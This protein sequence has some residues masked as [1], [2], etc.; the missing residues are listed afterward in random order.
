MISGNQESEQL[1][2]ELEK[3]I[4]NFERDATRI[5][6]KYVQITQILDE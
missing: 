2:A 4:E 6:Q 1:T 5:E 3:L